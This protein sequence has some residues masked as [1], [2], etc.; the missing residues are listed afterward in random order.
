M[1]SILLKQS[2][3][4]FSFLI[5]FIVPACTQQKGGISQ[6]R[7]TGI[8]VNLPEEW[9]NDKNIKWTYDLEG[10][11][12]SSPIISANRVFITTAV[13]ETTK[14]K[15]EIDAPPPPPPPPQPQSGPAK[16]AVPEST[17]A[18]SP[19]AYGLQRTVVVLSR[20]SGQP[21]LMQRADFMQATQQQS[22]GYMPCLLST[23]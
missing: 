16:R 8:G 5:F 6:F 4:A 14:P 20:I 3:S 12:W 1:K 11:G 9:G 7:Q 18:A 23:M 13:N 19:G 22:Q 21:I 2:V 15:E 17:Q 10:R